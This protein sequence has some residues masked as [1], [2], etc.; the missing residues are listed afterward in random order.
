M[1]IMIVKLAISALMGMIIGLERELKHKP[2]GVKTT[3]I[4]C[5]ISC[6]LTTVSIESAEVYAEKGIHV[7]DPM[8]LAAQIVSGV[9]FLGAGVILIRKNETITGITTAAMMW[10]SAGL[11]I[12]VG[13]GFFKEAIIGLL[14][15]LLSVEFIPF[16][17]KLLGP[18]VLQEKEIKLRL[19]VKA[20]SDMTELLKSIKSK[21]VSIRNVKV[22]D[23]ESGNHHVSLKINVDEKRYTTDVYYEIREIEDIISVEIEST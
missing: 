3:I 7:M 19:V 22:K 15:I 2:A 17:I 9:G 5:I 13:A 8:R 16:L 10:G 20:E 14:F 6:L 18:S 11:G 12:T 21:K 4:V 1:A 23:L